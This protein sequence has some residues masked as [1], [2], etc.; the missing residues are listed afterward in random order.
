MSMVPI[1]AAA[2][3]PIVVIDGRGWGHGVGMAQ[4]GALHM[5]TAGAS[6][7]VILRQF[8]PG[9]GYGRAR[10]PVRVPVVDAGGAPAS[11]IL[12]FPNGGE[13][14]ESTGADSAGFPVQVPRGGSVR[15]VFDGRRYRVEAVGRGVKAASAAPAA[16]PAGAPVGAPAV[17]PAGAGASSGATRRQ[18]PPLPDSSTTTTAPGSPGPSP[19]PT[20]PGT[21]EPPPPTDPAPAP[22]P[23]EGEQPP[24]ADGQP[25]TPSSTRSLVAVPAEAGSI[26]VPARQATYRGTIE[27]TAA[28][29]TFRL[30]NTVDIETYLKGMGEVLDPRWPPAALRAQAIAARTY[31]LRAMA[32]GGEICDTERCQVYLGSQVEYGAMNRAVDDT[33]ERVLTFGG[34]LISAVYSANGGGFS[35]SPEEGF[36]TIGPDV[37]YLRSAPYP[38][39]DPNPWSVTVSLRDVAARL[40]YRGTLSGV[41]IARTGPSQ[42]AIEVTLDG[43]AGPRAVTGRAFDAALGLRSTLFTV[44]VEMGEAP[45]PP[46]ADDGSLVQAPPEEAA[47]VAA[48]D[49]ATGPVRIETPAESAARLALAADQRHDRRRHQLLVVAGW[50]V[51]AAAGA[52]VIV[53]R[54]SGLARRRSLRPRRRTKLI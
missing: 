36:G 44:R 10:G 39:K 54:D 5:G 38:T 21:P 45:P 18:V 15:L 34:G 42:R 4:E 41:R 30:V 6:T 31:A 22:E 13:V 47:A 12:G 35:A 48:G 28:S 3:E 9:A 43:S 37:P 11:T 1:P 7:E 25:A 19:I 32:A 53:V 46:P 24:P 52:A 27:A 29:G 49:V 20:P 40:G 8:Y 26:A 17:G 33:R 2:A 51:I 50:M 14:R 23:P 16:G